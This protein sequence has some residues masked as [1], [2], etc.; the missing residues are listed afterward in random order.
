MPPAA[1]RRPSATRALLLALVFTA[2]SASEPAPERVLAGR[3][4]VRSISPDGDVLLFNR[5]TT[6][7]EVLPSGATETVT[8]A[9]AASVDQLP[10]WRHSGNVVFLHERASADAKWGAL[11]VW[12]KATGLR[13]VSQAAS[14][15]FRGREATWDDKWVFFFEY[16]MT[17]ERDLW[18]VR[19][20]EVASGDALTLQI[21]PLE[22][23]PLPRII[24]TNGPQKRLLV[25]GRP[26]DDE[27]NVTLWSIDWSGSRIPA[28]LSE[29]LHRA[30]FLIVA[31]GGTYA[32][33]ETSDALL[34]FRIDGSEEPQ[35]LTDRAHPY[36]I[37]PDGSRVLAKKY[38]DKLVL[39]T[40][41][42]GARQLLEGVSRVGTV[43]DTLT[44]AL[45]ATKLDGIP[46]HATNV[47]YLDLLTGRT[48]T[49]LETATGQTRGAFTGDGRYVA[50]TEE[51]DVRWR[52]TVKV[53]AV[54]GGAVRTI[55]RSAARI[56]AVGDSSLLLEDDSTGPRGYTDDTRMSVHLATAPFGAYPRLIE[57]NTAGG[58]LLSMDKAYGYF[59][60]DRGDD[61]D[62]LYRFDRP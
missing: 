55:G 6:A 49:L 59:A 13:P 31:R 54:K 29:S 40:E 41:G 45:V 28:V 9:Q 57:A 56:H 2:C 25:H 7:L 48:E 22:T 20:V 4:I 42:E 46:A 53:R 60:T 16:D 44:K 51:F 23:T 24:A 52:G 30:A 39:W 3:F 18:R 38:D 32:L 58:V 27:A 35:K 43:N 34:R 36:N 21:P 26:M 33:G 8:L 5:D 11:H 14:L 10:E 12:T 15:A 47:V 61:T 50:W 62:G 1:L 17:A 37:S 19:A